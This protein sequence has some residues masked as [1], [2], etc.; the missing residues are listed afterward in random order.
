MVVQSWYGRFGNRDKHGLAYVTKTKDAT[1]RSKTSL[2]RLMVNER[3]R[4]GAQDST[5]TELRSSKEREKEREKY[6]KGEEE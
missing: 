3:M 5:E 6:E 1:T 2:L 4:N